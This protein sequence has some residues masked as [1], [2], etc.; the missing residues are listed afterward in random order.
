MNSYSET[1]YILH[2]DL[3]L[4]PE[5][6]NPG[7]GIDLDEARA[8]LRK[9]KPGVVQFH[10]RGLHGFAT[11]PSK[12][13]TP[14]PCLKKDML[15]LWRDAARAEGIGFF[16]YHAG[17]ADN[18]AGK[19]HP[20]WRKLKVDGK[21]W[22]FGV[23][24]GE[25]A[26]SL[27]LMCFNG[28]YVTEQMY[29]LLA[30]IIKDYSP[31]GF[32]IDGEIGAAVSC[33]CDACLDKFKRETGMDA[34]RSADDPAAHEWSE[35]GRRTFREHLQRTAS[36]IHSLSPDC[37]YASSS[38]FSEM[39]P[40]PPLEGIDYLTG[41]LDN[42]DAYY[43]SDMRARAYR[44]QGRPYDAML[45]VDGF[46]WNTRPMQPKPHV[47]LS[48]EAIS[49]LVHN[50]KLSMWLTPNQ[51]G[52]LKEL[53]VGMAA[54]VAEFMR[55]RSSVLENCTPISEA[56][57]LNSCSHAYQRQDGFH[58]DGLFAVNRWA[59]EVRGAH[60]L[61][62]ERH[63]QFDIVTEAKLR[64]GIP[65]EIKLLVIPDQGYLPPDI[66]SIVK[67][68][69]EN[70]GAV[71]A[72]GSALAEGDCA[73]DMQE[74]FGINLGGKC[75]TPAGP[76]CEYG[77]IPVAT[78]WWEMNP[79]ADS[80]ANE[81]S[82]LY[83]YYTKKGRI[84][85]A[86]VARPYGKGKLI[87]IAGNVFDSYFSE[88]YPF[89]REWLTELLDSAMPAPLVRMNG[90][91]GVSCVASQRG[92]ELVLH[93]INRTS[94]DSPEAGLWFVDE[95]GK[96]GN[97]EIEVLVA[98]DPVKVTTLLAGREFEWHREAEYVRFTAPDIY[99]HDAVSLEF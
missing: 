58:L 48:Q 5:S 14:H 15:G 70:G 60:R 79:D 46:A 23:E 87:A 30:E 34:P 51:D 94:A 75:K 32:W 39:M 56:Y 85:P 13:G 57:V 36:F 47:Q 84:G 63:I 29:P 26:H 89:L 16:V 28:G 92:S 25:A 22:N 8:I 93:L 62:L 1:S 3:H 7:A 35:F 33:W 90:H 10:S 86:A 61:L 37:M 98:R 11:Y 53:E 64:S 82:S 12:V 17:I 83:Y 43:R 80:G 73:K 78:S 27:G 2:L 97:I 9:I 4:L 66:V 55:E 74:L 40:E 6:P 59:E 95:P 49:V 19:A 21:P 54:K 45:F 24:E 50:G 52:S 77:P 18:V 76:R 41:D 81:L 88:R 65:D 67:S 72:S 44:G 99:I 69:A 91:T 68:F 96:T 20:E 42:T 38:V 31:D 71:I